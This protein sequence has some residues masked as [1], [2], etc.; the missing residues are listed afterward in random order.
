MNEKIVELL[1]ERM[2]LYENPGEMIKAFLRLLS[3]VES[4]VDNGTLYNEIIE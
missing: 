3:P 2:V 4:G 1:S